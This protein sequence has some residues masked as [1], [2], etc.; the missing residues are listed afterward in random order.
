M[1]TA[2]KSNKNI[3]TAT[4]FK[5][6]YQE[7]TDAVIKALEVGTVVWRC[8]WN[9]IGLPK[10]ITTGV[11][12]RGWNVFWLNWHTILNGY[13]TPFYITFK[14]AHELGGTVKKSEKGIKITYWATIELKNQ[15]KEIQDQETGDTQTVIPTKLVPKEHTVFNIDQTEGIE[16]PRVDALQRD[17]VQRIEA[18]ERVIDNMPLR[19]KLNL[20]GDQAYYIPKMDVVVVPALKKFK[21]NEGYYSTLFHELAHSTG[22]ETRLNRKELL[23][24]SKQG[25]PTYAK[26]ELTAELTAAF[27][28][29]ITGIQQETIQNS[30]AYIE[31]WLSALKNDKTLVLKAAAQ[32][33]KAADFILNASNQ[34]QIAA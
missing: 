28:C 19:P 33:Q 21:S 9:K 3:K 11:Q 17:E 14:Q 12:Y 30:A 7:V 13:S 10:N 15:A 31:S 32:A 16:F 24:A 20:N 4:T 2:K 5:D 29:A 26:E 8:P 23:E 34:T 27:L 1:A 18:C 22:H 25:S 6:T